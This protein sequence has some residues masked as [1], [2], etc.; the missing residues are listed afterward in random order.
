MGFVLAVFGEKELPH[1]RP[2]PERD[3]SRPSQAISCRACQ[4]PPG[5]ISADLQV[6]QMLHSVIANDDD[7]ATSRWKLSRNKVLNFFSTHDRGR[8]FS[9]Y[10]ITTWSRKSFLSLHHH[11]MSSG[12]RW[13]KIEMSSSKRRLI[14]THQYTISYPVR[15]GSKQFRFF[16]SHNLS[17]NWPKW[18]FQTVFKQKN[19]EENEKTVVNIIWTVLIHDPAPI[20]VSLMHSS[21][22]SNRKLE[23]LK[24]SENSGLFWPLLAIFGHFWS[25]LT[26]FDHFWPLLTI[27]DHFWSLLVTFGH[28][29]PLLVTSGHF[30][31]LFLAYKYFGKIV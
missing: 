22:I 10:C 24:S 29:S 20:K 21:M 9:L 25:L 12:W 15:N 13:Q 30:W 4:G 7:E 23:L 27:F 16:S 1:R 17:I 11:T 2:V 14:K 8:Y 19:P 3:R 5:R 26:T 28:L 18:P 31:P 6:R